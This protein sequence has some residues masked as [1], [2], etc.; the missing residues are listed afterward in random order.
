MTRFISWLL[1][2]HLLGLSA[3]AQTNL[4]A[5]TWPIQND[6]LTDVVQWDHY[7]FELYGERIFLFGGE[8]HYWRL[9]VPELWIDILQ[10]I[11][12][13][14]FTAFTFYVNWAYHAANNST[15]DFSSGAHDFAPFFEIAHDLGLFVF[16]RPGPYINAETNA[17]G[18]PL[19]LTTGDYGALRNNDTRYTNAWTPFM[20]KVAEITVPYQITKGQNVITYQIENEYGD[21]WIGSPSSRIPNETAIQYMELLESN[22]RRSGI[23][24]PLTA[25]EPNEDAISWDQD[26]STAGGNV[27]ITG[28]DSYPSCWT[29]DLSQCTSTNGIYIPYEVVDYYDYFQTTQPKMPSF[30]PEFQG[31]SYNP[32]GGPE[33]GCPDNIGPDFANLFYRWNVGQRVTAMSLYMLYGGTN[34]GA[35]AAPVT[36]TSYDYSSPISEDRSI[37]DKYYETKL[38]ALFTRAAKDLTLTDLIGNGTQ[39][40]TNSAIRAY[41][42]RNPNTHAGFYVTLHTNSSVGT[43]E[44]FQLHVDTSTGA[45]TVPQYGTSI[46][47]N[48]YQSKI[49][50]T[51]FSFGTESLLYST[52]EVL[53]YVI[54]DATPTLALWVPTGESGEFAIKGATQGSV[55]R[56]QGCSGI[57]FYAESSHLIVTFTQGQGM[58]VLEFDSGTKIVLLDRTSAYLF[59]APTLTTNDLF[60]P[61]LDTGKFCF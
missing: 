34:W 35:S 9:P 48:G 52:A 1:L 20:S 26:W 2:L 3:I 37:G 54:Q 14:G 30:M 22:A 32:W 25:N 27:D 21:Q 42:L 46:R 51:D 56:C 5:S 55:K 43:N 40:T 59:W 6:G 16:L 45:L 19:W 47:L 11:K 50:V 4:T 7:S 12:A 44:T 23:D 17:G 38:L 13:A 61:E 57:G 28:L 29:C 31:G 10:K 60:A 49:V 8:F 15:L 39:Y 33:G 18:F 53:T 41:E 24:I 36:A 58:S